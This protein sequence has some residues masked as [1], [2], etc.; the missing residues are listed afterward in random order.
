MVVGGLE[1]KENS[2]PLIGE[3]CRYC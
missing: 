3:T 2:V 1:N